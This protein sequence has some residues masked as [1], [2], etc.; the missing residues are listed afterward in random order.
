MINH[1]IYLNKEWKYSEQWNE[2]LCDINYNEESLSSIELPHTNKELPLHYFNEEDYQLISGYRRH[3]HAE[4]EWENKV[5]LLTFEGIGH[6]ASVYV[7]QV[8]AGEHFC[9]YT[10]FT[11]DVSA[12][13]KYDDDN[14]ITVKVDSREREDIPP[15]GY[16]IDYLTY[17]GIYRE[18]FLEIKE[19]IYLQDVFVSTDC[20]EQAQKGLRSAI[21]ICGY[22]ENLRIEQVLSTLTGVCIQKN[23]FLV[24]EATSSFYSKIDG[25]SCWDIEEPNLYL[26]STNLY[27]HDKLIDQK[28][29]RFGFRE[30]KFTSNGF[31]LNGKKIKIVGLNRHQSYPYVGYAMP[32]RPQQ[33]DADILK[34]ELGVNAVR[35][36][37]YPQSQYFIDR[38]DEVGLVVF[39]EMPGW[40]HI[41]DEKWKDNSC[42]NVEEM[43][44]QYRNHPS[45]VLWGVR[46][47]ESK[48]D[49]AFYTRTNEIAHRLDPTRQTSGVRCIQKSSLL[50]DVY[51]Y[52][53]FLHNG[54]TAGM[55]EKRKVVPSEDNPYLVTEFN[56]HMYPTKSFDDEVHRL[57][58]AKRHAKVLNDLF[59]QEGIS[60]GFG[61]CMFDYNTHKDFGSGDRICYHGVMDM[62][63]NPKLAAS[64][65][66]SQNDA[67]V[68]C[69]MSSSMDIGEHAGS[70]I[71][72]VYAFTNGDSV[73]FYKNDRFIKEFKRENS[74]Y[75]YLPYAPILID[76]FVGDLLETDEGYSH[77]TAEMLKEVLI[78][79][80]E[81][82]Q[83][84]LPL[85]A[86]VKMGYL[87]VKEK[88]TIEKGT[89]LYT[90]YIGNWGGSVA[91]CRFDMMKNGVVM[92]SIIKESFSKACL[93]LE[94]DSMKLYDQDCYDVASIRLQMVDQ[95]GN[96]LPYYQEPLIIEATGA[97]ELI[98]PSNIS[99]HGGMGGT[100]VR[101]KGVAG[102]GKL[103]IMNGAKLL[104]EVMYEV[105]TKNDRGEETCI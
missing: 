24:S 39:T 69:E 64:V 46:I 100:Y 2:K 12:L 82:G 8:K 54:K 26:L 3:L 86:L 11:L 104:A 101:T 99:L 90:K 62:F 52:N 50:E 36:S 72:S 20:V 53:D 80:A 85:K 48:D 98:G 14:I 9:G 18:T 29:T 70:S 79:V 33:R 102:S 38:C 63:R 42:R 22:Q 27:H 105:N 74:E 87:M 83:N 97:I 10:A 91:K 58:H 55:E 68:T 47:N 37:H 84:S 75:N 65:Y 66:A 78:A 76:D 43:V 31:Y 19:S 45:I 71:G 41:G 103:K 73:R 6:V 7:N 94:C 13:L 56:G 95:N 1:K 51:A 17:G 92:K 30:T 60:G 34:Y 57:S 35:T 89:D 5:V 15:F 61:W 23:G 40:Q 49:D 67:I 88:L 25:V 81:H 93:K 32:K 59:R 4:K 96:L 21:S 16:V 44:L 77:S 28:V